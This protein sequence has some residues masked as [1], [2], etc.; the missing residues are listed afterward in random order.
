MKNYV[1]LVVV[2]VVLVVV[3]AVVVVVVSPGKFRSLISGG[4]CHATINILQVQEEDRQTAT[5]TATSTA[6]VATSF[7]LNTLKSNPFHYAASHMS[8]RSGG[9]AAN[10]Q[11]VITKPNTL[12]HTS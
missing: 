1:V 2:V 10:L 12:H 6:T 8:C 4:S 9:A 5:A 3:L 7:P 11:A